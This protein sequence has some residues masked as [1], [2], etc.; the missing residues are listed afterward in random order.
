MLRERGLEEKSDFP[1]EDI[2]EDGKFF[3]VEDRKTF[4]LMDLKKG[5]FRL[6]TSVGHRKIL[7]PH[8]EWDLRPSDSELRCSTTKPQKLYGERGL[9][10]SSYVTRPAY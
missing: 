1:K 6:V 9:L 8:E 7:S 4:A 2:E 10:R 5:V 3:V